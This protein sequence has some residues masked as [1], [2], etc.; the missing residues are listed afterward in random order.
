MIDVSDRI[1]WIQDDEV[2]R[3]ETGAE[4]SVGAVE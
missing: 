1:S 4:V 3:I 2:N